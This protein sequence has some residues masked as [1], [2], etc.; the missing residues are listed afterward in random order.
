LAIVPETDEG[1]GGVRK[2]PT[3]AGTG[4]DHKEI[5]KQRKKKVAIET[6]VRKRMMEAT[7]KLMDFD[8]VRE[9]GHEGC[10]REVVNGIMGK[11]EK[12]R[13]RE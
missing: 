9:G 7:S 2:G 11:Q 6:A 13:D 1:S 5:A 4:A 10:Q 12:K 8:R 3:S